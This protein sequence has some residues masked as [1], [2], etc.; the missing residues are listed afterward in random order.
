[1]G[2]GKE[3]SRLVRGMCSFAVFSP[4]WNVC[5]RRRGGVFFTDDFFLGTVEAT[6]GKE[7]EAGGVGAGLREIGED[8]VEDSFVRGQV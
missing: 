8:G 2:K 6:F 1:M 7:S 5:A 3:R 4:K